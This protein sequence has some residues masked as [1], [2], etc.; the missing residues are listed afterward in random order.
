MIFG[1]LK[2]NMVITDIEKIFISVA[3]QKKHEA[4]VFIAKNIDF[5]NKRIKGKTLRNNKVVE[6]I[7]DFP[8]V[9]QNRLAVKEEDMESYLKLAELIPFANNRIGTKETVYKIMNKVEPLRKYLIEVLELNDFSV[10]KNSLNK[11]S[12]IICKPDASNQGKG[13]V[14]IKKNA[15]V[16]IVKQMQEQHEYNLSELEEFTKKNLKR[17]YTVSPFLKSETHLG[18]TTVFRMHI[19]RGKEGKWQLI[20]FFPYVNLN[21]EIDITNGM[22]GALITTREQLFLEQYYPSSVDKINLGIRQLFDDFNQNFQ[23]QFAWRLD[24]IGLDLGITQD[25]DIYIYEV[26]VGPGVGFMAYSV[27]CAQV[28]YYEW[29]AIKAQPPYK[30]NFLPQ[31]LRKKIAKI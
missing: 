9:V 10:I 8:D 5:K 6:E 18:Q 16:Y 15:D 2:P 26:N 1:V 14:T 25:G 21:K 23:K 31:N 3:Q 17:G 11:Y 30:N 24:S 4:Y 13:I 20:K 28:D 7:F 22:L 19:T 27:A 29:L 12:K